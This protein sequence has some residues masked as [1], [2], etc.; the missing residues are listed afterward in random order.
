MENRRKII[1]HIKNILIAVLFISAVLLLSF[2]WKDISLNDL[3]NLAIGMQE[4]D[5]YRPELSELTRPGQIEVSFGSGVYT[6]ISAD[7]QLASHGIDVSK[8]DAG[9]CGVIGPRKASLKI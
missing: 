2:F 9:T 8:T 7:W 1:E 6:V 4:N 3:E 5:E